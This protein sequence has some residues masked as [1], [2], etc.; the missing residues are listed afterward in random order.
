MT[1]EERL[2]NLERELA[3]AKRRNRRLMIGSVVC[4]GMIFAWALFAQLGGLGTVHAAGPTTAPAL[5]EV[6]AGRF[7][8]EDENGKT[9]AWLRVDKDGAELCF[10][11]E[12]GKTEKVYKQNERRLEW[13]RHR[14]NEVCGERRWRQA[15]T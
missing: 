5:R 8:L 4:L 14:K 7:I 12:S 15:Q 1:T 3:R 9:W 11:D 6:R 2:E 10:F 13:L